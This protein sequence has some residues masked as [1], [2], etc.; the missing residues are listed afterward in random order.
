MYIYICIHT[1]PPT[2]PPTHTHTHKTGKGAKAEATR[3][4]QGVASEVKRPYFDHAIVASGHEV[5]IWQQRL[6]R[7]FKCQKR[8]TIGAKE[9]YYMRTLESLPA[10]AHSRHDH[11]VSPNTCRRVCPRA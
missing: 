1:H 9:T 2:H 7:P 11:S 3:S 6:R 5:P 10:R 4:I 8:P